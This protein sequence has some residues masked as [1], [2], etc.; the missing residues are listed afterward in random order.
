MSKEQLD[1]LCEILTQWCEDC[2]TSP[3][4]HKKVFELWNTILKEHNNETV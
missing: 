1:F 4:A 2:D 3:T